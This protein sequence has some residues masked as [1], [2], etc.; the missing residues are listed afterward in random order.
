MKK[1]LV[2]LAALAATASFAQS[3]VTISGQLDA[4]FASTTSTAGITATNVSSGYFGANRLRFV[5]VEDMGGGMKTN[6]WLEMQPGF[7]GSTSGNGLFNRGAWAVKAP[8]PSAWFARSTNW[9]ATA[10][11]L[12]AA[13]CSPATLAAPPSPTVWPT[14]LQ[15]TPPVAVLAWLCPPWLAASAA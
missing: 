10:P 9:V 5:G 12:A 8:P 2:A 6:F 15:P 3:S 4:G 13:S 1:T 14:G 7:N 11:S